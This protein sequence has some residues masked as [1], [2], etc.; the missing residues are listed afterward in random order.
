MS[1]V[2]EQQAQPG[3]SSRERTPASSPKPHVPRPPWSP[4]QRGDPGLA[5]SGPNRTGLPDAL[6][7]GVEALS[8]LAMDDVRVH[9]NSSR[10]TQL[11]ALA[12]AQGSDIHLGP[13][14]ERHLPHEAWHVVQQKQGRVKATRQMEGGTP[15]NDDAG[16]EREADRMG[17][18]AL[19]VR[20]GP[21]PIAT[22]STSGGL[23]QMKGDGLVAQLVLATVNPQNGPIIL[24]Q[25]GGGAD[26][27]VFMEQTGQAG[28]AP[29]NNVGYAGVIDPGGWAGLATSPRN[30][31]R[32]HAYAE[33]FGGAGSEANIGWWA[34]D[35]E[36]A[37]TAEEQKVR[38]AGLAQIAA[39]QPGI[40]EQGTY[41]V[42]RDLFPETPLKQN[43]V[44]A[45]IGGAAWGFEDGRAAWLRA[46]KTCDKIEKAE[47]K[48]Q[49]TTALWTEKAHV[50]GDIAG[51]INTWADRLFGTTSL[52]TNLIRRMSLTYTITAPGANAG[53]NRADLQQ[54]IDAVQP[55]PD[56]FGLNAA[57]QLI[58]GALHAHN[59]GHFALGGLAP[60]PLLTGEVPYPGNAQPAQQFYPQLDGWGTP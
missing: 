60:L 43:Y 18:R 20:I 32:A 29:N 41:L 49:R 42:Q 57:P 54:T 40:G 24:T 1:R 25:A 35:T 28:A 12:Y 6:K 52:D 30:Y 3:T 56:Q 5:P 37:W 2:V 44:D 21:A 22:A 9:R 39:W 15:V 19:S 38:G 10:P 53:A 11:G 31:I 33:S 55:D 26:P 59:A 13:G 8:G 45:L 48:K 58:W 7:A 36:A 46:L 34:Q 51:R 17:A 27:L 50:R 14:E 47:K 16:L 23:A 4:M